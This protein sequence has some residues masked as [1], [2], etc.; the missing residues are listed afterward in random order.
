MTN[1]KDPKPLTR[2]RAKLV[3]ASV[4]IYGEQATAKDAAFIARELIQ[5][6]LPHK[7]PGNVPVWTRTNGNLSLII[8]QGYDRTGKPYG[9]P[10]G[11]VPRLLLFWLTTE[12]LRGK[13]SENPRRI[14]L[15]H[16]LTGFMRELGLNPDNGSLGAKRSD[17]RR[18]R[19]QM[20]RLFRA[21]ISFEREQETPQASGIGWVEMPVAPRG[22]L[23]WNYKTPEQDTIFESWIELGEDFHKAITA[24]PVPVDMRALRA[25][26][27]SALALDLYSWL[28]YEAFR[29]HK[30]GKPRFE[31]WEQLQGHLGGEYKQVADFR[32]KAKAALTKIQAVY[33]NLKLGEKAGGIQVLPESLPAL[34]PRE[35]VTLEGKA[36][37][38]KGG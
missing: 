6:T 24:A 30:S 38:L 18:L 33:P 23:W 15:G 27:S 12:A 8:Q 35:G 32:R 21:R 34:Q 36:R 11:T 19:E 2:A 5:A 29:A 3:D 1:T 31:T 28:T 16:S 20:E 7:S 14:A 10:F 25:L 22:E 4:L 17:A 26:K 37:T 9:Y 13:N